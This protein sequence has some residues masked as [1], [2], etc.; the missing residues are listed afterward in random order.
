[1]K[2]LKLIVCCFLFSNL[3]AKGEEPQSVQK[4]VFKPKLPSSYKAFLQKTNSLIVGENQNLVEMDCYVSFDISK[5]AEGKYIYKETV[6]S[7][8][9]TQNG[10]QVPENILFK[11]LR[12]NPTKAIIS[13]SGKFEALKGFESV[14][15]VVK[16]NVPKEQHAG[17]GKVFS[18][19]KAKAEAEAEW[20][21]TIENWVG[22]KI[23]SDTHRVT[24][25]EF[26][27]LP[28]LTMEVASVGQISEP[29]TLE[30]GTKVV[31]V[32]YTFALDSYSLA[33][34]MSDDILDAIDELNIEPLNYPGIEDLEISGTK[35]R[36]IEI[37]TMHLVK[38]AEELQASFSLRTPVG[39]QEAVSTQTI[40]QTFNH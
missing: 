11:A 39:W 18:V 16:A 22:A 30:N 26:E 37:D 1:M 21:D 9:T 5:S 14:F 10:Q 2:L 36:T 24:K 12:L 38:E 31:D 19:E 6:D 28:G 34:E 25:Q 8:K 15:E 17:L 23:S 27:I 40:S 7:T 13:E 3:W 32:E 29:Y 20:K 4:L 35:T 33:D